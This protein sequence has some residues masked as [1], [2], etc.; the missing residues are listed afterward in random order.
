MLYTHVLMH[1]YSCIHSSIHI[2]IHSFIQRA[3]VNDRRKKESASDQTNIR[4][5]KEKIKDQETK[6]KKCQ[7]IRVQNPKFKSKS[8]S[9]TMSIK[10]HTE[11]AIQAD[12]SIDPS[13]YHPSS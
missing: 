2:S 3:Y 8:I 5:E 4:Q 6:K 12:R 7:G 1:S 11:Y 10:Y 13:S 9:I